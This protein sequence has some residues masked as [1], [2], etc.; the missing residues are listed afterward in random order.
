MEK[1]KLEKDIYNYLKEEEARCIGCRLC[2]EGCPMLAEFTDNPKDLLR[3]ILE[4]GVFDYGLPYSCML[5]GYCREVCPREVDLNQV[6]MDMRG[7]VFRKSGGKLPK[8][9]GYGGIRF[10]QKNSFSS[11]FRT[12][13]RNLKSTRVFF[14]GCSLMAYSPDIVARTYGY[15]EEVS[16]GIG[17]YINCCGKPS[18]SM[19]DEERF[20]QYFSILERDFKDRG[21][22]QVVTACLNCYKTLKENTEGIEIIS[23][24]EVLADQGLPKDRQGKGEAYRDLSLLLHDPCPTR[25]VDS[26]HQAV[27]IILDDLGFNY[28]EMEKRGRTTLCC[29]SG[30]MVGIF[31]KDLAQ[32]RRKERA[33][34]READFLVSYCEECVQSMREGGR[35]A[36]HLLDLI[37]ND[38]VYGGF[39][40]EDQALLSKWKNRL[41]GR[42][43]FN[44]LKE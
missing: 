26:I 18:I 34:E 16:P 42:I 38:Q 41:V 28:L 44:K 2:M 1:Y 37:F 20:G 43:R 8:D 14:P 33:R 15:L 19:G 40:Q 6:F 39:D 10:H 36:V 35:P 32:A 3:G 7:E 30:G 13:I 23:L 9:L 31:R 17:I 5:C 12:G 4:E 27:R 21:V 24:W 22:D 25:E 11:V 29:G